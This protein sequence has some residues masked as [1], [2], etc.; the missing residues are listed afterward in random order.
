MEIT[1]TVVR[2]KTQN[3]FFSSIDTKFFEGLQTVKS[4]HLVDSYSTVEH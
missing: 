4:W 1:K 2:D 3:H